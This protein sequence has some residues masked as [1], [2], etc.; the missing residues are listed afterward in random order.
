V[1][2]TF[3]FRDIQILDLVIHH[4]LPGSIGRSSIHIWDAGCAMGQETYSLAVLLAESLGYF[5]FRNVRIHATDIEENPAFGETVRSGIYGEEELKRI[6]DG[7]LAKYFQPLNDGRQF[8][9]IGPL[10]EKITYEKHDLLS[11]KPAGINFSAI[12]CKN[13][14]LHFRAEERIEVIRM[15]RDSLAPGGFLAMEQTQKMPA[16]MEWGFQKVAPNGQIFQKMP[17]TVEPNRERDF[18]RTTEGRGE[19]T[20]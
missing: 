13:V 11:L 14:L 20:C 8:Q 4:L 5:S 16:E 19:R 10:R 2:F 15:F 7:L 9:A 1:A 12:L 18:D 3:F 6:P 17:V